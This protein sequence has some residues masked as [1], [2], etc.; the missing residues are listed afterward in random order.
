[1]QPEDYLRNT[2][3]PNPAPFLRRTVLAEAERVWSSS[4]GRR[5]RRQC[6]HHPFA[7]AAAAAMALMLAMIVSEIDQRATSSLVRG[8]HSGPPVAEREI[9]AREHEN[10]DRDTIR[11]R[12]WKD[13]LVWNGAGFAGDRSGAPLLGR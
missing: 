5:P 10:P 3:A 4:E 2:A 6:L 13:E 7:A 11:Y 1:M 12:D 9:L 8:S